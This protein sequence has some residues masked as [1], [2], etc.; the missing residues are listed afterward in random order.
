M[1]CLR[2]FLPLLVI[3]TAGLSPV[4]L[5]L[6]VISMFITY[7]P[8]I[9]CSLVLLALFTTS[10]HFNDHCYF[11]FNHGNL[12]LPNL[13]LPPELASNATYVYEKLMTDSLFARSPYFMTFSGL[14]RKLTSPVV[15]TSDSDNHS[16]SVQP[17]HEFKL[18]CGVAKFRL[19]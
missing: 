13:F 6:F 18:P 2:Y 11:D 15:L 10:C 1:Y 5:V 16:A 14:V 4:F 3:P 8:C 12:F 7:R 19:I 9:Y 17:V